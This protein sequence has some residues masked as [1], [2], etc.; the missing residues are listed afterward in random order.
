MRVK[1]YVANSMPDALARIRNDLGE[2]AVILDSK[3]IK[4]NGVWG[5]FGKRRFEVIAA[6]DPV[7][8]KAH[9]PIH[10]PQTVPTPES[11]Q[12]EVRSIKQ[13]MEQWVT[14]QTA[15]HYP[16]HLTKMATLL[17]EQHVA[18]DVIDSILQAAQGQLDGNRHVDDRM[19]HQLVEN[20]IKRRFLQKVAPQ[21]MLEADKQTVYFIGPTGVGKTTTIAKI[22]ATYV[23]EK[24]LRVGLIAADTYRIAAVEQ[25]KTY[26]NILNVPIEVVHDPQEMERAKDKLSDCDVILVDTAGRNYRQKMKVS[27]L[28]AFIQGE[29]VTVHLV[30]SLTM[31]DEDIQAVLDNF[32]SCPVTHLLLTK[33]DETTSYGLSL[34]LACQT[35]YPFS[36]ITTGQNVPDDMIPADAA[37]LTAWVMGGDNRA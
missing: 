7:S 5:W 34:N 19:V 3:P 33:A 15:G 30:L 25:L 32:S 18:G 6:V 22:A 24:G 31:R 20:E 29:K 12:Q 4:Q 14:A 2:Q 27:E 1:R 28:F 17:R 37:Q 21:T 9:T 16:A 8:P 11:L 13:M 23:L 26:A 36:F 35:D 10:A